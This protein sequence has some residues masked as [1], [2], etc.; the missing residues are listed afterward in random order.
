MII[1]SGH[2]DV[3]VVVVRGAWLGGN[4]TPYRVLHAHQIA[5]AEPCVGLQ[6]AE[7]LSLGK[8]PRMKEGAGVR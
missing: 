1:C 2:D 6:A 4:P 7:S 5:I 3:S 8:P